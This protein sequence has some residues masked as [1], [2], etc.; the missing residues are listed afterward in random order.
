MFER[1]YS[2]FVSTYTNCWQSC[3]CSNV[4]DAAISSNRLTLP[5]TTRKGT[6]CLIRASGRRLVRVRARVDEQRLLS[7]YKPRP[8]ILPLHARHTPGQGISLPRKGAKGALG[9]VEPRR[10]RARRVGLVGRLLN[11]HVQRR[12]R[13][14]VDELA[15]LDCELACRRV[16]VEDGRPGHVGRLRLQVL[17][18]VWCCDGADPVG[19]GLQR[20]RRWDAGGLGHRCAHGTPSEEGGDD[21]WLDHGVLGRN[22]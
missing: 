3:R 11:P 4:S 16:R 6:H 20:C 7:A 18:V 1:L 21:D 15:G 14:L 2:H 13:R 22:R 5:S 12:V 10:E 8:D 9:R 19:A 17:V